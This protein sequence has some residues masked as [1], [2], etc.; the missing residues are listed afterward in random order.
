MIPFDHIL[1]DLRATLKVE[2]VRLPVIPPTH[3]PPGSVD[4]GEQPLRSNIATQIAS[5][6]N[7]IP[8]LAKPKEPGNCTNPWRVRHAEPPQFLPP[9]LQRRDLKKLHGKLESLPGLP[10]GPTPHTFGLQTE[11]RA[12]AVGFLGD[13]S[14]ENDD[15]LPLSS[16][17]HEADIIASVPRLLP[18][19]FYT[20]EMFVDYFRTHNFPDETTIA[21]GELYSKRHKVWTTSAVSRVIEFGDSTEQIST[22]GN[23]F[24]HVSR[25]DRCGTAKEVVDTDDEVAFWEAL[26][27]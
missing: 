2:D 21:L 3:T 19:L 23:P 27:V 11:P 24:Y 8:S 5:S 12:K 20:D 22:D 1:D 17:S 4:L 10:V 15:S 25:V 6:S 13:A 16:L 14:S 9:A 7:T 26:K 18:A